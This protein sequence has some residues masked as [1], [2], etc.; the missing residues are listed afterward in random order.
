MKLNAKAVLGIA[1]SL[2]LLW[3]ALRDVSF[4]EVVHHVRSADPVL[5]ALAILV[6]TSGLAIRALR[7]GV[8]LRPVARRV[9]FRPR[10]AA[11]SVGFAANNLLPARAGEF[12]RALTLSRL[13]GVPIG[14]VFG[15]LALER[16]FDGLVL[17]SLLFISLAG[18]V[19]VDP[20]TAAGL[21]AFGV[22]GTAVMTAAVALLAFLPEWSVRVGS[23]V[24]GRVLPKSIAR[25]LV[26]AMRSFVAA[27]GVL[28]DPR[29]FAL[30]FLWAL[31]Q[32]S[33]LALSYLLALRAFGIDQVSFFGA[34]FLQSLVSFGV[35]IPSSPGFFGPFEAVVK[36][37]L[38]IWGVPPG[39][40]V[41]L[42]I[43]FHIGGFIPVTLIGIWYAWRMNLRW[44]EVENAEETVEEA[45]EAEPLPPV[46]GAAGTRA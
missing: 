34:V 31:G 2:L 5:F 37:G 29:L 39:Q 1:V 13:A 23:A 18:A 12:A 26:D 3:W 20:R 45:V 36:L 35:A 40:A 30:S 6:A 28:R 4:A 46:P 11:T 24:A 14:A 33:F 41:S 21:A 42:A 8:L 38:G 10:Y 16:V 44:S 7:W 15:T 27:L 43:G 9:P 22:L 32:W 25:P 19:P 17:V